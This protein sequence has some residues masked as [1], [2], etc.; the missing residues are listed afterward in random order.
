MISKSLAILK[1]RLWCGDG[2]YKE[3]GSSYLKSPWDFLSVSAPL[4][5]PVNGDLQMSVDVKR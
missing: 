5:G 4:Q 2:K 3:M 1:L